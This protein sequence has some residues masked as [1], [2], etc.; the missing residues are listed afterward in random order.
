MNSPVQVL[1]VE[2]DAPLATAFS[3]VVRRAGGIPVPVHSASRAAAILDSGGIGLMIL[4][5]GLPDRNGLDF[6]RERSTLAHPVPPVLLVTAH[7]SLTNAI[8]A[9]RLGVLDFL[10]KPVDLATLQPLLA[11][12]LESITTPLSSPRSISPPLSYIGAADTMRPVFQGIA[13]ACSSRTPILI[14]GGT[15]TGKTTTAHLIARNDL[16]AA[17]TTTLSATEDARIRDLLGNAAPHVLIIEE[18]ASLSPESQSALSRLIDATDPALR[19][20]STS[21]PPLWPLVRD[22]LFSPALYYRLQPARI[23]LPPLRDRVTD[24]PAFASWFLGQLR[25]GIACH[26]KPESLQALERHDWPGNLRELH[27]ALAWACFSS[28]PRLEIEVRDLPPEITRP[29]GSSDPLQGSLTHAIRPWLDNRLRAEPALDYRSLIDELERSLLIELL[30]H[31]QNKPSRLASVRGLNR[32]T[33][34]KRL[35]DLGIDPRRS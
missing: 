23:L 9:K 26:L 31:H 29:R 24:L 3:V 17:P 30:L 20:I 12:A 25:P 5:I 28:G 19:I 11:A 33:L 8:E 34:R 32:S 14:E 10:E 13:Q 27:N 7:G 2:D 18:V 16:L 35:Q 15:G 4:D 6:L 21:T 1:I 22:G